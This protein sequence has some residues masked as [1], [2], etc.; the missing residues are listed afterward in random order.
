MISNHV[1]DLSHTLENDMPV[2]PGSDTP[3]IEQITSVAT[4]GYAEIRLNMLTHTGTHIDFPAHLIEKGFTVDSAPSGRFYG[5]GFVIDC[6]MG[7]S[8]KIIRRSFLYQYERKLRE[9]DFVLFCT[10]WS[11]LWNTPKYNEY[12]PMLDEEAA[13]Y[14]TTLDLKGVGFD[15]PSA[16]PVGSKDLTVHHILLGNNIFLIENLTNLGLLVD[17]SFHFACFPLKIK[18]GDGSP[19]RA[20]GIVGPA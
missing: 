4:H 13:R 7:K 14:L 20:V 11:Q 17:K 2:Y 5:A 15:T 1:I 10:G 12:F 6:R 18:N 8:G 19:V 16:D 3:K 9:A